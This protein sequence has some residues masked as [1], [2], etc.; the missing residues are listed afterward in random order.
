[1]P[2]G[3]WN[4]RSLPS[5]SYEVAKVMDGSGNDN[6]LG[7]NG[8]RGVLSEGKT[9]KYSVQS[10]WVVRCSKSTRIL[11]MRPQI[12]KLFQS[13]PR[14]IHNII[15]LCD[16]CSGMLSIGQVCTK[17]HCKTNEVLI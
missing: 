1:M 10:F 3:E 11:H 7:S 13:N 15:T 16:W 17:W 12:P 8:E 5:S 6:N 4:I 9:Y 2:Q 14:Y